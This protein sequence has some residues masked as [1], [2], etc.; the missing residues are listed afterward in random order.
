MVGLLRDMEH[1]QTDKDTSDIQQETT[2][3]AEGNNQLADGAD[4]EDISQAEAEP[5]S[6]QLKSI[7]KKRGQYTFRKVKVDF[8]LIPKEIPYDEENDYTIEIQIIEKEPVK[9]KS[10]AAIF[11]A[12]K[13]EAAAEAAAAAEAE[14]ALK[15]AEAVK[16][17][18]ELKKAAKL[19]KKVT[20]TEDGEGKSATLGIEEDAV[21]GNYISESSDNEVTEPIVSDDFE[22]VN[23]DEHDLPPSSAA[24]ENDDSSVSA[25]D[26]AD[27]ALAEID[28][29]IDESLSQLSSVEDKLPESEESLADED[30]FRKVDLIVP[31]PDD[32]FHERVNSK[33]IPDEVLGTAAELLEDILAQT[34]L[35]L[36]VENLEDGNEDVHLGIERILGDAEAELEN[37]PGTDESERIASQEE[38][39]GQET[40]RNLPTT[41][42]DS[43]TSEDTSPKRVKV[44]PE[45]LD[46]AASVLDEI[47]KVTSLVISQ[48]DTPV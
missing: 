46:I 19:A 16:R 15:K 4:Q 25:V 27:I 5:T 37:V 42:E 22:N 32:S 45:L 28:D 26:L 11:A 40:E 34:P 23:T 30:K 36:N 6:K 7:L 12:K 20:L 33:D 14:E 38:S 18:E 43:S 35:L 39:T 13:A 21:N 8:D 1:F 17:K 48:V 10:W 29:I 47:E 24:Q 2:A 41:D 3:A 44:T 31:G 9:I